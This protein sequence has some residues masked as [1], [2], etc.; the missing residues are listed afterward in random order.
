MIKYPTNSGVFVFSFEMPT[1]TFVL[2]KCW[3]HL[4]IGIFSNA[5]D[6][7]VSPCSPSHSH[8]CPSFNIF[9][10]M[11]ASC[12]R[13]SMSTPMSTWIGQVVPLWKTYFY[14]AHIFKLAHQFSSL[15]SYGSPS[16]NNCNVITM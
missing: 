5:I 6:Q 3:R 15:K 7:F 9:A 8:L 2:G 4:L 16:K 12:T 14:E 11:N 10:M 13:P 1:S